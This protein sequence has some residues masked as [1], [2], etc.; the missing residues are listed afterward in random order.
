M[1]KDQNIRCLLLPTFGVYLYNT[2]DI[3]GINS[4]R[5]TYNT[6]IQIYS[7]NQSF[8]LVQILNV[9]IV[10]FHLDVISAVVGISTGSFIDNIFCY[11]FIKLIYDRPSSSVAQRIEVII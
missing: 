3:Y 9:A 2:R 10:L 5:T 1:I 6:N 4:S 7:S 11:F 8:P